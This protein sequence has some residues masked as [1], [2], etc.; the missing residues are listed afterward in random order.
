MDI[1]KI[2]FFGHREVYEF[3]KVEE[4]LYRLITD[5]LDKKEYVEFYVGKSGDFDTIVASVIKKIRKD[6]GTSN[7]CLILVLPYMV[8]DMEYLEKFYDEICVPECAYNFFYKNAYVKRN[9]WMVEN[10]DLV[11][12]YVKEDRQ[13]GG[14]GK[15]LA[16]A[17]N[18]QKRVINIDEY[19]E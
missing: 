7:N 13:K 9:E 14:A 6:I 1:Y 17:K 5:I 11:V 19:D 8:K 18:L 15:A 16:Y 4:K 3:F 12:G 10:A 2:A